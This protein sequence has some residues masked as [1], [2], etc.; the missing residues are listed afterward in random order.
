M[1]VCQAFVEGREGCREGN[2]CL[3]DHPFRKD[4]TTTNKDRRYVCGAKK[5]INGRTNNKADHFMSRY[6]SAPGGQEEMSS[7]AERVQS[8]INAKMPQRPN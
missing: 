8:F 5:L 2:K 4:D 6:C 7:I 3:D 1:K